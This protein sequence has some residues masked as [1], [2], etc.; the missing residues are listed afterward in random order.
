VAESP[1]YHMGRRAAR[2]DI[3][4]GRERDEGMGLMAPI[5]WLRGYDDTRA[6]YDRLYGDD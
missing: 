2:D 6:V 5:D 3:A 1:E 4:A